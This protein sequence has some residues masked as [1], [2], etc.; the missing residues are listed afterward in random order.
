M[1]L[2]I[3]DN[4]CQL[5]A[6]CLL[7]FLVIYIS[8]KLF[9]YFKPKQLISSYGKAVLIT[10]CDSGFGNLLAYSLNERGFRVYATCLDPDG[11]GGQG[12][13]KN[14]RFT[15]QMVV[16]KMNVTDDDNV[17]QVYNQ[18]TDDLIANKCQLWSVVNNAG[19]MIT[20]PV[21][22]GLLADY[23]RLF[24][25]NVFGVV[26]VT[27]IF[28]PLLRV[29]KGRIVNMS[30]TLGKL[31]LGTYSA[32][33]MTKASVLRFSDALRDEMTRFGVKVSTIMPGG[34]KNTGLFAGILSA[35]DNIWLNT[36][37][38]IKSAYGHK[39]IEQWK[40]ETS[41][42]LDSDSLQGTDPYIVVNDMIDAVMNTVPRND[43]EPIGSF[44]FQ[45]FYR[46]H[47]ILGKNLLTKLLL[48]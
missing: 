19:Y 25:V 42:G 6:N 46:L 40:Q 31:T 1:I 43:Y 2:E 28:L 5:T 21:E 10:G 35:M 3:I 34:F 9:Y 39:H 17:R 12:L 13:T 7:I 32:Y 36:D 24:G 4:L 30:S 33:C 45:V 22:W 41:K 48:R 38:S 16:L 26:R 29:S 44:G 37:E 8:L 20:S 15:D 11:D 47:N 27:R 14:S 18:V 23:E